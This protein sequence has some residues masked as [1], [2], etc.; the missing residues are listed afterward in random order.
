MFNNKNT[1]FLLAIFMLQVTGILQAKEAIDFTGSRFSVGKGASVEIGE[2]AS[3]TVSNIIIEADIS[4]KGKLILLSDKNAFIDANNHSIEN[5]VLASANK[6]ELLSGLQIVN[7]LTI[8]KGELHLNNFDLILCPDAKLNNS[9]LLKIILNG[10]GTIL[11][12][13]I[14]IPYAAAPFV[15]S[16][17]VHFDFSQIPALTVNDSREA[18]ENIFHYTLSFTPDRTPDVPVPP[19]KA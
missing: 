2:S 7:E 18:D 1:I 5:L 19:P 4:G 12:Q 9:S 16:G 13:S 14:S 6:V 17:P 15:F 11:Q 3:I 10:S 8:L